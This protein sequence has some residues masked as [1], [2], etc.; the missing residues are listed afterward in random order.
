MFLSVYV[1]IFLRIVHCTILT[2]HATLLYT[3]WLS[4]K[5]FEKLLKWHQIHN[6]LAHG[7]LY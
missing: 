7:N 2:Q 5:K 6:W 3:E 4:F 1:F